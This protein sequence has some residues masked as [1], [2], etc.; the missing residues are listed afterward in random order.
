MNANDERDVIKG[1][2]T[3]FEMSVGVQKFCRD[4]S[5]DIFK[6]SSD[7][8]LLTMHL[9]NGSR[10]AFSKSVPSMSKNLRFGHFSNSPKRFCIVRRRLLWPKFSSASDEP[11]MFGFSAKNLTSWLES[12]QPLKLRYRNLV[13]TSWKRLESW[14]VTTQ[15]DKSRRCSWKIEK[16]CSQSNKLWN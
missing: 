3:L 5:S 12:R 14:S 8:K 10:S 4:I 16:R 15:S 11:K 1:R 9:I 13:S 2:K 7:L 6:H